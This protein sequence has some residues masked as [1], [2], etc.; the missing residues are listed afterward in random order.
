MDI[1]ALLNAAAAIA[2]GIVSTVGAISA[3]ISPGNTASAA[4]ANALTSELAAAVKVGTALAPAL[5]TITSALQGQAV[6]DAGL[7]ALK[8]A[9]DAIDALA[10]ADEQ[11]IIDGTASP[12]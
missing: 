10:N 2:P 4:V 1:L 9:A 8:A 11:K 3:Y 7:A 12:S 5:P 6:N